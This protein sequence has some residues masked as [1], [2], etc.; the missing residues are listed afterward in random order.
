MGNGLGNARA[1]GPDTSPRRCET[2]AMDE[3]P[4][5]ARAQVETGPVGAANGFVD[6]VQAGDIDTACE[7]SVPEMADRLRSGFAEELREKWAEVDG[8]WG[9]AMNPKA[10]AVDLELVLLVDKGETGY[11]EDPTGVMAIPFVMQHSDRWKVYA[12]EMPA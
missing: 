5:F 6:A 8:S 10:V 9:W 7:L 2:A 12:L 3:I 4:D 1:R 11:I